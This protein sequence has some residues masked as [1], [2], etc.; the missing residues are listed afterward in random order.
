MIQPL[1]KIQKLLNFIPVNTLN[2]IIKII[3][4]IFLLWFYIN[5]YQY[6]E[7]NTF[8]FLFFTF[9]L[10]LA[11][12]I[13]YLFSVSMFYSF[14]IGFLIQWILFLNVNPY[15]LKNNNK[16]AI[17]SY[18]PE[19]YKPEQEYLMSSLSIEQMENMKYPIIL[20][21][22]VCSG[23]NKDIFIVNNYKE[24]KNFMISN[25]HKINL[26]N[27]MI[28]KY[29]EDYDIEIGVFYEQNPWEEKGKIIN[30]TEKTQKEDI[31][32]QNPLFIQNHPE[33]ITEK[34]QKLFE[35]ISQN[36]PDFYVG[37]YDI[38]LKHLEDLEK[39]D[40]KILEV[41]G[42]MGMMLNSNQNLFDNNAFIIDSKWFIRRLQ[43][44]AYNMATLKGYNPL[45]LL[46]VM[47]ISLKNCI[48]CDDWENLFSLYS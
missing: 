45:L 26:S 17:M 22:I 7:I 29:M 27:Y 25:Q 44:G 34:V 4:S 33:L 14:V 43:I 24:F 42:T 32:A 16:L 28:Q 15:P 2:I 10:I 12:G 23:D 13:K 9:P 6:N 39:G 1:K 37:R 35:T 19:T 21:P 30:I 46:Q 41:N 3:L 31:R 38:R 48:T 11:I 5:I 47:S 18:I 20:K 40:F 36:I 8:L